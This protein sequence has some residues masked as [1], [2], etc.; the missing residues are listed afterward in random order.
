LE[1]R[2]SISAEAEEGHSAVI[3]LSL[4][5]LNE[6]VSRLRRVDVRVHDPRHHGLARQIDSRRS[7]WCLELPTAAN[8]HN[9]AP[10]NDERGVL[11]RG[12][13]VTRDQPSA[14]EDSGGRRRLA[15][16]RNSACCRN[17]NERDEEADGYG[18]RGRHV[19]HLLP[20]FNTTNAMRSSRDMDRRIP[21]W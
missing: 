20:V 16:N 14:A 7:G 4:Q 9:A 12:A 2:V 1:G 3:R 5:V 13:P 18:S 8:L 21:G 19:G 15:A 17:G 6:R 11:D 10:L